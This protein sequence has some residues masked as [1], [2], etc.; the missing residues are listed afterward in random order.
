MKPVAEPSG[1]E[2]N[3][4]AAPAPE[5]S[6]DL[7][8]A[9]LDKIL[10]S[11]GFATAERLTR[12]LR[13]AVEEALDGQGDRLKESL[14]GV[15]VFGRKP[16]YDPRTD[17]VVRTEAVKLRARL[18]EY[19]ETEGRED[20]VRI[21]LPKGRYV[22]WFHLREEPP[23]PVA[24]AP[25][26]PA[27]VEPEH[28]RW[29]SVLAG[30][31]V[32]TVL[33]A[34]AL[35]TLRQKL[36]GTDGRS[37]E[38][39]SIAVLPF[40]DLSPQKDQEYFCDGMT[41]EIID[42]LTKV[43]GFRVVARTSSFAFKDKQQDI[44]EIGR[45]LNVDAVLEGSVRKSGSRLRVTAQLVSVAD[46]YHLWSE[47]YE[48]EL[49]DVFVVQDEISQAIVNTLQL[50]LA[51]ARNSRLAKPTEDLTTYDLYLKGR[52]HWGRWRT[53][54]AE[55]A[56]RYFEQ[57]IA[58]DPN[59]A[60]AYAGLAD[61]YCWRGFF[62]ALP[63]N[64]AM[65]KAR[66]AALKAIEL[67]DSLAAAHASLGYVNALYNFDWPGAEREFKRA[68][69]LNPGLA[70][71]HFGYGIVYL[72][73][74][75][76]MQEA[77]RELELARDLDP[78]SLA[79]NTYLALVYLFN[80]KREQAIE[81]YKKAI[82]LDPNFSEPHADLA[83]A[84]MDERRWAEM[85]AELD[86]IK[87]P[88]LECRAELIRATADVAQGKRAEGLAILHKW[89]NPPPHVYVRYTSIANVYAALGDSDNAF[90]WLDKAYSER[91]GMLAYLNHQH[92]WDKYR[93]DSR[94][95]AL[96]NKLGLPR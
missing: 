8:R 19:Y 29:N 50:K 81:Q 46:G 9:E 68:M 39:S 79:T 90:R 30:A 66:Q 1:H 21:D 45:R 13:Y 73:P 22:P 5:I 95:I 74:L 42:V 4:Q 70:D 86:K 67:D 83:S 51:S 85:E 16:T 61:A 37:A 41:D 62:S 48:R 80:G 84:Y 94:F 60:A 96:L 15:E 71:A 44:R 58:R 69:Q 53:E 24:I 40:V 92:L 72:T 14:L 65:P 49:K 55:K 12:F 82:D 91:D 3:G 33:L 2:T 75:G 38:L 7:I 34:T 28:R 52:Y 88:T 20:P 23:S 77:Q 27:V 36:R 87:E 89:E 56:V 43:G 6:A 47:T 31:L 11:P 25:A 59:Y 17:A 26:E 64:E 93:S 18:K 54:G 57:A 63:P 32:V 10:A 35:F 78:L 76:R